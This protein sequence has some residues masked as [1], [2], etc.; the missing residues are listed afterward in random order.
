MIYSYEKRS[1]FSA[2]RCTFY[3]IIRPMPLVSVR[4]V[5]FIRHFKKYADRINTKYAAE[6]CENMVQNCSKP[7]TASRST[8]VPTHGWCHYVGNQM[9]EV[10]K[11]FPILVTER[12]AR[13]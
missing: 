12:W 6:I 5:S 10:K 13:S 1:P 11:S 2:S 7:T 3:S 8:G 9:V 4:H